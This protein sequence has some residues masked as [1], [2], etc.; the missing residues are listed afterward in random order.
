[1]TSREKSV[2]FAK[3]AEQAEQERIAAEQAASEMRR[4]AVTAGSEKKALAKQED[5]RTTV[6]RAESRGE[7]PPDLSTRGAMLHPL[8]EVSGVGIIKWNEEIREKITNLAKPPKKPARKPVGPIG[9]QLPVIPR[10]TGVSWSSVLAD[11][12]PPPQD[13][14][15]RD[16]E[17]RPP[18]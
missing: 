11:G 2:Y 10:P 3:L 16:H 5:L 14:T 8:A 6:L 7:D 4:A 1:M 13:P 9:F 15:D 12:A 18:Y 17:F